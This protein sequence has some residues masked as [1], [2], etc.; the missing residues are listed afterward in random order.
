[1][2][3]ESTLL[4]TDMGWRPLF[5]L[6]LLVTTG[7]C[8]VD[9]VGEDVIAVGEWVRTNQTVISISQT[10]ALGFFDS[11]NATH[12]RFHLG[13]WYNRIPSRTVVWVANRNAA[14]ADTGGGAIIAADGNLV[15]V[16]G[17]STV[18]W[19]TGVRTR[20]NT[21][22]AVLEE[23]GNLVLRDGEGRSLW[24]SFDFPSD[25]YLPGMKIR[26]NVTTGE[27][28]GLVSWKAPGDPSPGEY[29]LGL[30]PV[31]P[32]QII[33]RR[34]GGAKGWRT[35]WWNN[36]IFSE[37]MTTN[38]LRAYAMYLTVVTV[39]DEM[40][41]TISVSDSSLIWRFQLN[42]SGILEQRTWLPEAGVWDLVWN[43]PRIPCHF[44]SHC[45]PNG[46]CNRNGVPEC[47]CLLGTQPT[48][49][50][51]W[52]DGNW[53]A[54]CERPGGAHCGEGDGFWRLGPI[55]LPDLPISKLGLSAG[56][57]AEQCLMNCSCG[58]YSYA[59]VS[60]GPSPRCL[61]WTGRLLDLE[62]NYTGSG[63][64]LYIRLSKHE[65]GTYAPHHRLGWGWA[66][67][68]LFFFFYF[69]RL[70]LFSPSL[71]SL[72]LSSLSLLSLFSSPCVVDEYGDFCEIK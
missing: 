62:E 36:R 6:S 29:Y 50:A 21:S 33:M 10:F 4:V 32:A 9:S 66:F 68:F 14:L 37:M 61:H 60:F 24:Q 41:L 43:R 38:G 30:D 46:V 13:I 58:A 59:N 45:G 15:V 42:G 65:L 17:R 12:R 31:W 20:G 18:I 49:R 40:A 63:Q 27:V 70:P 51:E 54:G 72:S 1:M 48:R 67:C 35:T 22:T 34:R 28:M 53:S 26:L 8:V 64:D 69:F 19:S 16:D 2:V 57:C 55:K 52:N 47:G 25:T 3:E 56:E 5:L 71:L 7:V 44:Y 39:A 11:G 23:S